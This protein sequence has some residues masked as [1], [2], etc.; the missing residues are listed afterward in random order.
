M[1]GTVIRNTGSHYVVELDGEAKEI[2]CKIKGD[3][4]SVV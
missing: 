2:C 1:D 4:K 3:R